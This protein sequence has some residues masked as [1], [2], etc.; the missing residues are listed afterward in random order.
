MTA[1][2]IVMS[3]GLQTITLFI[4]MYNIIKEVDWPVPVEYI[5]KDGIACLGRSRREIY[6]NDTIDITIESSMDQEIR[7]RLE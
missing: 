3:L 6:K 4:P 5:D 1:Q 2:A 7:V